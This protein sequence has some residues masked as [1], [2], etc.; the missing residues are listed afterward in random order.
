MLSQRGK[1]LAIFLLFVAVSSTVLTAVE[2]ARR[3]PGDHHSAVHA[4]AMSLHERARSLLMAWVAQLT[5]GP[6]PRGPGH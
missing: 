6:S 3:L 1:I 2:A 4:T 5:A